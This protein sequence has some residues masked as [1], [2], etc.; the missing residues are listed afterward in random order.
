MCAYLAS[1]AVL[2]SCVQ[3][4]FLCLARAHQTKWYAIVVKHNNTFAR[5]GATRRPYPLSAIRTGDMPALD[6]C[7]SLDMAMC[8]PQATQHLT[9]HNLYYKSCWAADCRNKKNKQTVAN[10][11]SCPFEIPANFPFHR[12]CLNEYVAPAAIDPFDSLLR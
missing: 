12:R 8:S 6:V 10:R 3:D 1:S 7:C 11:L 9:G 4:L 5:R 2:I